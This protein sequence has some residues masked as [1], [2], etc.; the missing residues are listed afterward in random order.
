MSYSQWSIED[1]KEIYARY[2]ESG[3]TIKDF[4]Y[5][6]GIHRKRFGQ[7]KK[8]LEI[9]NSTVFLGG[10][11]I[12]VKMGVDGH[13]VSRNGR[14]SFFTPGSMSP[15]QPQGACEIAYP[16]GATVRLNGP[17]STEFLQ[18]LVLLNFNR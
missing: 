13:V 1:F 10:K 18:G 17:V 15:V 3:L 12:P 6:E 7:W 5:N 4:C 11:F 9:A 14:S 8:K 16:N 2:Q